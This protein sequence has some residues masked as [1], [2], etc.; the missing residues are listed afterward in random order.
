MLH[1][2]DVKRVNC[3]GA[4]CKGENYKRSKNVFKQRKTEKQFRN[5]YLY[6]VAEE[7]SIAIGSELNPIGISSI[8]CVQI[9]LLYI[10]QISFKMHCLFIIEIDSNA[11]CVD[12]V[13]P[14][15][16][17]LIKTFP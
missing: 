14:E 13:M 7:H 1:S 2:V 15:E 5:R 8:Q 12:V 6:A 16:N 3:Q 11:H 4:N 9:E 17:V 10:H